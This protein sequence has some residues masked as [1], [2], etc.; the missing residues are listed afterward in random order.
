MKKSKF[1]FIGLIVVLAIGIWWG[2]PYARLYF[3]SKQHTT[4]TDDVVLFVP[5]GTTLESLEGLLVEHGIISDVKVFQELSKYKNLA[6][7]NIAPGKYIVKSAYPLTHLINGFMLNALGNG[8][9]EQEVDVTFNYCRDVFDLAGKVAKHIE[10]DSTELAN[11][12]SNS[13][14]IGTLGF[15]QETF[16]A[17]FI[18]DTYRFYWDTKPEEFVNRMAAEFKAF[19]TEKRKNQARSL[20]LSQSQ[21]VTLASIVYKEQGLVPDEWP[22]IAGLYL[23][24]LKSNWRLESDPTFRFCWGRKLDGVQRLT[25][26]HRDIDCPYNTYKRFGLPPGPICIPPAGAID[27]VLS[28]A[29]HNYFFMCAKPGG[30]NR[31][32]FAHSYNEHLKNARIYQNWLTSR[33]IK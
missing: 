1:L 3:A 8:N 14:V 16:P 20:N 19:W 21:V 30:E 32:S 23:N 7:N 5:T 9:A 24:R 2:Y 6:D 33:N 22:I 25:Y 17:L 28:P 10:A 4:N 12:L 11:Y 31:H 26:E 29:N 27:A 13:E 18:P 15:N